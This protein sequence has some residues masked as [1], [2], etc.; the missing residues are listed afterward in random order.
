MPRPHPLQVCQRW[1]ALLRSKAALAVLWEELVLDFGH[2]LITSVHTP[3]A[4]SDRRCAGARGGGPRQAWG[5]QRAG[6]AGEG[7]SR[8]M[9]SAAPVAAS[10][11]AAVHSAIRYL[12]R[13]WH[14]RVGGQGGW[15]KSRWSPACQETLCVSFSLPRP[16]DEEFRAAF[17]ATRLNAHRILEFVR[18]RRGCIRKLVLMHSEGYWA[19]GGGAL[20]GAARRA[21]TGLQ[22]ALC[23]LG[24]AGV[25]EPRQSQWRWQKKVAHKCNA[26]SVEHSAAIRTAPAGAR[27]S[28]QPAAATAWLS[29]PSICLCLYSCR[30]GGR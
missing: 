29:V 27:H 9:Q 14:A 16:G 6:A 19:G 20:G 30:P 25:S 5:P 3:V 11:S 22:P 26:G 13:T 23:P 10:P 7:T 12:V 21:C 28:P 1:R 4:W 17:A 18:E 15:G 8:L 2:E 24:G